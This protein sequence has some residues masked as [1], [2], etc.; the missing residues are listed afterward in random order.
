MARGD[1]T[2][3]TVG[4]EEAH[5]RAVA[6]DHRGN[7]ARELDRDLFDR[8]D[9]GERGREV[10]QRAGGGRVGLRGRQRGGRI[11]C[12]CRERRVHVQR[13]AVV[14]KERSPVAIDRGEL[15]VVSL[16]GLNV[17][18]QATRSGR[19]V[20]RYQLAGQVLCFAAVEP[21]RE[22]LSGRS[23]RGVQDQR[24][25]GRDDGARHRG[26]EAGEHRVDALGGDD[27]GDGPAECVETHLQCLGQVLEVLGTEADILGLLPPNA[28]VALGGAVDLALLLDHL[29][30]RVPEEAG[31]HREQ[32]GEQRAVL[33]DGFE[34]VEELLGQHP[35]VGADL[36]AA[37]RPDADEAAVDSA[38]GR[39]VERRG[40]AQGP[41]RCEHLGDR[42]RQH[43]G[44]APDRRQGAWAAHHL[45]GRHQ[46]PSHLRVRRPLGVIEQHVEGTRLTGPFEHGTERSRRHLV[47]Q[48]LDD[49]AGVDTGEVGL[50]HC[51]F[52]G[53]H[54]PAIGTNEG[55][56]KRC[57][58]RHGPR[59]NAE[60]ASG[61]TS[62]RRIVFPTGA[63]AGAARR[64]ADA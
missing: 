28:E 22:H 54:G 25:R 40:R 53:G 5:D 44:V 38:G 36:P 55:P 59:G 51:R 42:L 45:A 18:H 57:L 58:T 24:V 17:D 13:D 46:E 6:V 41:N 34:A 56:S 52:A 49:E 7:R 9:L 8:H 26:D 11:E 1:G 29:G 2:G 32:S 62:V 43:P 63:Q 61:A 39:G 23:G 14:G 20:V 50:R 64:G 16:G 37:A 30:G 15:S 21:E 4:V 19:R 35:L 10:E 48:V 31:R 12:R 3:Q 33:G 47:A 27:V 60:R